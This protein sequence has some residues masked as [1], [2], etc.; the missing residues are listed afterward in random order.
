[1]P[2]AELLVVGSGENAGALD[3]TARLIRLT[4]ELNLA[5]AVRFLGRLSDMRLRD[6]YAAADVF[7]LPS[8]SEAQGIVA[9]E[10]MAC[11]LPVVAS[12]V[13][14]L[15]GTIDD[16]ESGFLVPS[17]DAEALANRLAEVFGDPAG[18][19]EVGASARL[20]V[21]RRFG[22]AQALAATAEVYRDVVA[23]EG[24]P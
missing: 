23:S 24:R 10:A 13:G 8:T 11:G 5:T 9:L 22:W 1:L 20:A 12:A 7:A 2:D 18:R 15:L 19:A 6:A 3:Q 17:G 14:G 4:H 21:E 16:H